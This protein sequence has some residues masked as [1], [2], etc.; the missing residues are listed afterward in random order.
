MRCATWPASPASCR[1]TAISGYNALADPARPGGPRDLGLLLV[2]LQT[3]VL[4]HRQRQAMRRSP[5]RRWPAYRPAICH[6]GPSIRGQPPAF[7][8]QAMRQQY[9]KPLVGELFAWLE[10]QLRLVRRS[11]HIADAIRYGFNHQARTAALPLRTAGSSR[12]TPT[13]LNAR[14]ARLMPL[15]ERT[16]CSPGHD[17]GGVHWGVVAPH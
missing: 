1:S 16:A 15:T 4:R 9:T 12:S 3:A 14:S 5:T 17:E 10:T 13:P 8:R 2:A 6:R 11:S 7:Q